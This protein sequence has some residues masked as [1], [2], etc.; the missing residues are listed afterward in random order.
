MA[1]LIV[2]LPNNVVYLLSLNTDI[3]C[4]LLHSE[5]VTSRRYMYTVFV[6]NQPFSVWPGR[7]AVR[8]SDL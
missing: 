7:V 4:V 1:W 3:T 8:A 2:Q 6:Y 5:V